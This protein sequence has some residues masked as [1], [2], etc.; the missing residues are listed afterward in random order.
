MSK[1][2]QG[3]RVLGRPKVGHRGVNKAMQS[4]SMHSK[5]KTAGRGKAGKEGIREFKVVDG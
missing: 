1:V 3:K 4:Q 2:K 5:K